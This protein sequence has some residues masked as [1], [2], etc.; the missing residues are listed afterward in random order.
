MNTTKS[1]ALSRRFVAQ[2]NAEFPSLTY[3]RTRFAALSWRLTADTLV[4]IVFA[5]AF[6]SIVGG[7]SHVEPRVAMPEITTAPPQ[8]PVVKVVNNGAIFQHQG[9]HRPLFEDQ[10]PRYVGDILT[11]QIQERTAASRSS[12]S[13]AGKKGEVTANVPILSKVPGKFVQGLDAKG[14]T[15]NTFEGK[16]ETAND[17]A[18]NGT[19]TVTVVAV[20]PNGNLAIAGEKQIGINA[21]LELIRFSGVVNPSSV[22]AGNNVAS[23]QVADARLE[24]RGRGYIDEAQRMGWLQRFFLTFLPF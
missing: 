18:F 16:G 21:N 13:S 1:L 4:V 24:Y 3:F 2:A 14:S 22:Q 9:V 7:C 23:N 19:I 17:N 10:K 5:I 8:M 12:K 15:N 20:L 6:M 11:V